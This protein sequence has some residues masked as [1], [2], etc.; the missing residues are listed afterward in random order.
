MKNY[1]INNLIKVFIRFTIKYLI[2]IPCFIVFN[3]KIIIKNLNT[4]LQHYY[5]T[6]IGIKQ[7]SY[8]LNYNKTYDA[9]EKNKYY[10]KAFLFYYTALSILILINII[11]FILFKNEYKTSISTLKV[12]KFTKL[13]ICIIPIVLGAIY[14]FSINI[15][16]PYLIAAI[17]KTIKYNILSK[18]G[19]LITPN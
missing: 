5:N 15:I 14:F 12:K 11:I 18:T 6:S 10:R 3:Y 8:N 9:D 19:K 4:K 16:L 1:N 17:N 2:F 13:L 7:I